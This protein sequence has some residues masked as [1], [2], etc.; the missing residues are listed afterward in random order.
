MP[1][2]EMLVSP[3]F[4]NPWYLPPAAFLPWVVDHIVS[5]DAAG[6]VI[7]LLELVM[8]GSGP[9]GLIVQKLNWTRSIAGSE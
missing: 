7:E 4:E 8:S 3:Y 5:A 6:L 1:Q 2:Y 9:L